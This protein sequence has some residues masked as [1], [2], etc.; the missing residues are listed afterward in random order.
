M[1]KILSV[2]LML[3]LFLTACSKDGPAETEI[4]AMDTYMRIRIW[5]DNDLLNDAVDEIRRLEGLLSVTDED[6]E[7]NALNQTG[8]AELS[9]DTAVILEAAITL[10]ERTDGA[11]D[12][13]VYPLVSA[14]GFTTG[15][16]HVLTQEELDMLLPLVG[17]EHLRL[18]GTAATLSDGAQVDLGGIAKGYTAQK[19]LELL[20]EKGVQTAMLSLGGNVQTLGTKPDGS[21]WVIGIAN[22]ESPSEAIATLTFTD[23]MAI[24]TSGGYQRY[25][26]LDGTRYHHIL[27]PETGIP[28]ETGLSSVTILTQDGATADALSTALFVM[29]IER[30]IEFWRE[31]NDF[32]AVFI[33]QSGTIYATEGAAPLLGGCQFEEITR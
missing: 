27:N 32:E 8:N 16:A 18:E 33:T 3:C 20:S 11:F 25:F 2:L 28:A 5:G 6:S 21:A 26:D 7:V 23:S 12:P 14:W 19:C 15:E 17:T 1:K 24:V 13:T 30:G 31:S 29:G 4:F 9:A 10:S 22:P